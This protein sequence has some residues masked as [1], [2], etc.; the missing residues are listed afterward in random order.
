MTYYDYFKR[1]DANPY[2]A[3]VHTEKEIQEIASSIPPDSPF[4]HTITDKTK[5][6]FG[7][8][9]AVRNFHFPHLHSDSLISN[10]RYSMVCKSV[11]SIF[12]GTRQEHF[13]MVF[14]FAKE[15]SELIA[16]ELVKEGLVQ[17]LLKNCEGVAG[18]APFFS[19]KAEN[20]LRIY[21]LIQHAYAISGFYLCQYIDS[22]KSTITSLTDQA[23]TGLKNLEAR[24]VYNTD[25]KF[26]NYLI[27]FNEGNLTLA[28]TDFG[29]SFYLPLEVN[30]R[31]LSNLCLIFCRSRFLPDHFKKEVTE[32]CRNL[33]VLSPFEKQR[34]M[35][36]ALTIGKFSVVSTMVTSDKGIH[37][38]L[39]H[40]MEAFENRT[41]TN[42]NATMNRFRQLLVTQIAHQVAVSILGMSSN[43]ALLNELL[44]VRNEGSYK[45]PKE[46]EDPLSPTRVSNFLTARGLSDDYIKFF[47]GLLNVNHP[48]SSLNECYESFQ[49]ITL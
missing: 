28:M 12:E 36:F 41:V 24:H 8:L 5:G 18:G 2:R 29:A 23:L 38:K 4:G 40:I 37:R 7:R 39:D 11:I 21:F 48:K 44:T 35:F 49:Q 31:F 45:G 33:N 19:Y 26:N 6:N 46:N 10:S 43:I 15:T 13:S 30:E 3:L 14:K 17:A 22:T 47:N 9:D 42:L 20:T 16:G 1:A 34:L 25:C 32:G 27:N